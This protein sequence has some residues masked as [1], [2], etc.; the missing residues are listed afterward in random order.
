MLT[1]IKGTRLNGKEMGHLIIQKNIGLSLFNINVDDAM[2]CLRIVKATRY[3][4]SIY[5]IGRMICLFGAYMYM[6]TKAS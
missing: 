3:R 2:L 5:I 6:K 4:D 1:A